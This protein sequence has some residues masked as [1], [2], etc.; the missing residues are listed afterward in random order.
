M[1]ADACV[2]SGP[3]RAYAPPRSGT[4]AHL[5]LVGLLA[6]CSKTPPS[7]AAQPNAA[8]DTAVAA[9]EKAAVALA[10]PMPAPASATAQA[11]PAIG[12]E[13]LE[14]AP[15]PKEYTATVPADVPEVGLYGAPRA[16]LTAEQLAQFNAGYQLF[17]RVFSDKEGMG[18]RF[19]QPACV[20]CHDQP[21]PG[22]SGGANRQVRLMHV[23]PNATRLLP[24]HAL[25]PAQQWPKPEHAVFDYR[26]GP[27]LLGI[28][29][30]EAI[31]AD[32]RRALCDPDDKDGDGVRGVHV[33]NPRFPGIPGTY[34]YQGHT[35]SLREFIGNAL[36]GEM[37]MTNEA[38]RDDLIATD[39]DQRPDPE[40]SKQELDTIVAYVR[41]LA[42][43]QSLPPPPE[44]KV[45][46]AA[47][48]CATCH[49]PDPHPTAK[50][51]HTD[52]CVH[53]LGPSFDGKVAD[54]DA[55]GDMW[56]TAPLW[57]LRHRPHYFHDARAKD[58]PTAIGMHDGEARRARLAYLALAEPQRQQ[59]LAYLRSL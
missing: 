40:V 17:R 11:V 20:A 26:A 8:A 57:G 41:G 30:F 48:G 52:L 28:G 37:G 14:P 15:P 10:A 44:G 27:P 46:F 2:L 7:P 47:I 9:P 13:A 21:A 31:T 51:A 12:Y 22:G 33:S 23:P 38:N 25:K 39:E 49:R 56:R 59:V 53:R 24:W 18:P 43:P 19:N 4:L 55:H 34:G 36:A 54:H 35:P 3:P 42:A 5:V 29:A 6:A 45:L 16:D 32:E 50:G 58:L 1:I